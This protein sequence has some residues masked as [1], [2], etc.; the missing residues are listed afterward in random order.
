VVVVI[1]GVSNC[2]NLNFCAPSH[3]VPWP[4]LSPSLTVVIF[5]ERFA[6][7]WKYCYVVRGEVCLMSVEIQTLTC[8]EKS[9]HIG[10]LS[11]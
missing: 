11:S 1:A 6:L 7:A 10:I 2:V 4:F 9:P 8:V 5:L 3:S